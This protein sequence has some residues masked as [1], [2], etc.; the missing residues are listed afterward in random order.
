[1]RTL[2]SGA[3]PRRAW[4]SFRA[5]LARA[6]AG[7]RERGASAVEWVVI[8]MIVVGLC[9]GAGILIS[10]AVSGKATSIQT[11]IDNASSTNKTN[12]C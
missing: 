1:M 11:C 6:R 5:R 7:E 8:S 3:V 4:A 10:T 12:G 9:V 2:L